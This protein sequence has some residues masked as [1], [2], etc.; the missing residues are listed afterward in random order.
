MRIV[1]PAV[2][3]FSAAGWASRYAARHRP[4]FPRTG[5]IIAFCFRGNHQCG[6]VCECI[7][8]VAKYI[9]PFGVHPAS[10]PSD[11]PAMRYVPFPSDP[12]VPA[13]LPEL[14]ELILGDF[15]AEDLIRG[16][17]TNSVWDQCTAA[18]LHH[19]VRRLFEHALNDYNA[20]VDAIEHCRAVLGGAGAVNVAFPSQPKP[21]FVE[22][23]VPHFSY[24]NL[25]SHIVD[26]QGFVQVPV[27]PAIPTVVPDTPQRRVLPV[28]DRTGQRG[29]ANV[30]FFVKG[31]FAIYVIQSS[32]DCA[33]YAMTGEWHSGLFIHVGPRK[34]SIAY[35]SL[36]RASIA[37]LNPT[38]IEDLA[39]LP[40]EHK[41]VTDAW[42]GMGWTLTPRWLSVAPGGVC[43]GVASAGCAAASRFFGDQFC[44]SGTMRPVRVRNEREWRAEE[45][46]ETAMWWR[47]GRTCTLIC[48][49]GTTMIRGGAR[50]CHRA[51]VLGL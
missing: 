31:E 20:F 46:M 17:G 26:C 15:D 14:S 27:Q 19:R 39:D 7:P 12:I 33:L 5:L 28:L 42:H 32:V 40:P 44:V 1:D 4:W 36:T 8:R 11:S 21:P 37:L 50:V 51:L 9:W 25:L 16:R 18:I 48:H 10:F 29:V 41:V 23:F 49:S 34:F 3:H 38:T 24:D 30:A 22:V 2:L 35:P 43:S 13:L 45:D 47:G 6:V